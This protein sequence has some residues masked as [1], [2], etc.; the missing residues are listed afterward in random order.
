MNYMKI[1]TDK[2]LIYVDGGKIFTKEQ[3]YFR[4]LSIDQIDHIKYGKYTTKTKKKKLDELIDNNFENM[5]IDSGIPL[6]EAIARA[7]FTP[8]G[9][10][11]MTPV[12]ECFH[13]WRL[14]EINEEKYI[15]FCGK[16]LAIEE[17]DRFI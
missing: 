12:P 17:R 14:L 5:E 15:F 10:E 7:G 6:R 9:E 3:K 8:S 11:I 1:K 13:S 2:Y 4:D 16:C